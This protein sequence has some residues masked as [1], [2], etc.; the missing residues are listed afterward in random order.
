MVLRVSLRLRRVHHG[1]RAQIARAV[2]HYH[3]DAPVDV[4]VVHVHRKDAFER[5]RMVVA[6]Q[7]ERDEH[8][9]QHNRPNEE[10]RRRPLDPTGRQTA[11]HRKHVERQEA[12][13]GGEHVGRHNSHE[14]PLTQR[15]DVGVDGGEDGERY[16]E[17]EK[18]VEELHGRLLEDGP[19]RRARVGSNSTRAT[20][21]LLLLLA[22][23]LVVPIELIQRHGEV[24]VEAQQD[25]EHRCDEV[26]NRRLANRRPDGAG[27][28]V[29]DG[30][31]RA[32]DVGAE[33]DRASVLG[34]QFRCHSV[35]GVLENSAGHVEDHHRP[36]RH[37]EERSG[38]V[39]RVHH[40]QNDGDE[41]NDDFDDQAPND[42]LREV[43]AVRMEGGRK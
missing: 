16:E 3:G 20:R 31:E 18:H 4:V 1:Q 11:E 5:F 38:P 9:A 19:V 10:S 8:N 12:G 17:D 27:Q 43:A 37:P 30:G 41:E 2:A 7:E 15:L 35:R 34:R 36:H 26:I 23:D 25:D 29:D 33:H 42:T 28:D 22:H 21:L 24:S 32:A 39:R 40:R 13:D 6:E 14:L